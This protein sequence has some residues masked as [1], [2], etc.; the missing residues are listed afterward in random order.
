MNLYKSKTYL[1]DLRVALAA[2]VGIA[3][4]KNK[5]ILVTGATG[6]IGSFIVDMLLEYNKSGAN[7][8]IFATSRNKERLEERFK[9][10]K[11]DLLTYVTY[12][13]LIPVEFVFSVDYIIHAGG[14]A[15]PAAFNADPVGTIRG[16]VVGTYNLL[17][18]GR[19]HGVKRFCYISSGEVYGQGDMTV[20]SFDEDYSGYIDLL[21]PRSAY[22]MG[23]RA[24]E[25]L[26][27]SYTKQYGLETV[28]VR[29]CHTYGPGITDSDSRAHAQFIRN[30]LNGDDIIMKS[31]GTQRRSYCYIADCASAILTCLIKGESGK[32]YNSANSGAS[33]SIARLAQII[34]SCAGRKVVF[35]EP[36]ISDLANRTPI[37]KQVLSSAKLEALGWEGKYS[38]EEGV[39]HTLTIL[40]GEL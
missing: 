9:V 8:T 31:Q 38:V 30:V 10:G 25:T 35:A 26:C 36:D 4:M 19:K 33:I 27:A 15:H 21:S 18:Y 11:T 22:P 5:T 29:P 2:S 28:I 17:E 13:S 14:N 24:A 32:A 37:A 1:D 6:T 7:I 20:D 39:A 12:D 34:A 16:S 3:E 23:K 40:R